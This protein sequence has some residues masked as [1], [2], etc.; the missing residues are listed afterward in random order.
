MT[1]AYRDDLGAAEERL[2]RLE[3]SHIERQLRGLRNQRAVVALMPEEKGGLGW[4]LVAA[5]FLGLGL[6]VL[7]VMTIESAVLVS[8]SSGVGAVHLLVDVL[9]IVATL[10]AIR[11]LTAKSRTR[12]YERV[13]AEAL[14]KLDAEIAAI[15]NAPRRIEV[16]TLEAARV[17]IAELEIEEASDLTGEV[18]TSSANVVRRR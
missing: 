8:R 5:R 13:R 16:A 17:R 9:A 10:F 2:A 14:A 4:R 11:A 7:T 15:E 18:A 3:A 1:S 6:A 12:R